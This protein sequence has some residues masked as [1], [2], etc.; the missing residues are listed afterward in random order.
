MRQQ[1]LASEAWAKKFLR[2]QKLASEA[3]AKKFLRQQKLAPEAAVS[4][5]KSAITSL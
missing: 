1:K 3:W 2:Q 4:I 5:K